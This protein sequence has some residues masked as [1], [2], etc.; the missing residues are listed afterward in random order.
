MAN[1]EKISAALRLHQEGNLLEAGEIYREVLASEPDN[2]DALNLMGVVMQAAGDLELA[3]DLIGRAAELAP[4][5]F[6]P[7]AN[8]GNVYQAAGRLEEALDS[9]RRALE[10]N[11][12]SAETVNNMAS[13][14]NQLGRHQEA[15]KASEAALGIFPEFPAA[16]LNLGNALAALGKVDQAIACYRQTIEAD[17]ESGDGWFNLGNIYVDQEDWREAQAAFGKALALDPENPEKQ[18]N[19]ALSLLKCEEYGDAARYFREAIRNRPNYI[20]AQ[21]NLASALQA[22]GQTA[23]AMQELRQALTAEPDSPDLHWNLALISLQH[24]DY[25]QG[26]REYEWRWK[27]PTFADFNRTFS[28]P[29][30]AGEPLDRKTVL[31]TAEQGFGDGIQFARYVPML[32]DRGASVILECRPQLTGLFETLEGVGSCI[33]LGSHAG[34]IDFYVPLMSLPHIFGTTLQTV[35]CQVPYLRVPEARNAHETVLEESEFKIGF[36]WAGSATRVDNHKRSCDV[37]LFSQLFSLPGTRFFSLQVGEFSNQLDAL[38][39]GRAVYDLSDT[40]S[41]FADTAAVIGNLDVVVSVDTSVLHLAGA[42]GVSAIGLLSRPTGFL[43]MDERRDSP[44]Y[45]NT[46]LIRQS[47]SGDWTSVFDEAE[48]ELRSRIVDFLDHG[49]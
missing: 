2:V 24:G 19:L 12:D 1:R 3:A 33:D 6:G 18:Y 29:Q 42:L 43:W 5:Y 14:F 48:Q 46:V 16:R 31:V 39:P 15:L 4:D 10:L 20:D 49:R 22:Q 17:P 41:D 47:V 9:F 38:D 27:T 23:E 30:W 28:V 8:L 32:G 13:L 21:C 11:P 45:P 40:L 36:A 35:P 37:A 34:P 44:W 7:F 25:E 26:W